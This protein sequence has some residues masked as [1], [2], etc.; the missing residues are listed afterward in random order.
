MEDRYQMRSTI[1][2]SQL[3]VDKWHEVIGDPSI[4]DAVLDRLVN[5]AYRLSL[6]GESM[7]RRLSG[8]TQMNQVEG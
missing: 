2:A 3:P 4:A 1:V 7:R 5:N 8:L 6:S